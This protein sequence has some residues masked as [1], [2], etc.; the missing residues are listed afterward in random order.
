MKIKEEEWAE[1]I[2]RTCCCFSLTLKNHVCAKPYQRAF[3]VF[4]SLQ[5]LHF[6]NNL[7]NL[8]FYPTEWPLADATEDNSESLMEII[9]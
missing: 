5:L 2:G 3:M 6:P 7:Y 1:I 9:S 4:V 8:A